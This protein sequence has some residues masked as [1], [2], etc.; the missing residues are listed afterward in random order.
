MQGVFC[1]NNAN[2]G[3]KIRKM[4]YFVLTGPLFCRKFLCFFRWFSAFSLKYEIIIFQYCSSGALL[5]VWRP[6]MYDRGGIFISHEPRAAEGRPAAAERNAVLMKNIRLPAFVLAL[7]LLSGCRREPPVS[8]PDPAPAEE[9]SIFVFAMD[10]IM[11]LTVYGDGGL[12]T[13]AQ[14]RILAL[15]ASLSVTDPD[16]EVYALNHSGSAVLSPE[17]AELLQFALDLCRRTEGALDLSIYP[18]LR[19]WGFT[20]GEYG[21]P[22]E[23][24]LARLLELVDY[25]RIGFDPDSRTVTLE[26]GM[27]IDF[28]SVAKGYTGDR[29]CA[30]LREG[31]VTSALLDLG[32][33]IQTVGGKPDGRPWRVGVKDPSGTGYVGV[34]E[35]EDKAVIT[36]GG[37]E[38]YFEQDGVVY[39]HLIDPGTGAPA[40]SG[41]ISAT[42]VGDSGRQ[43]DGLSTALFVMG[44]DR[45]AEFWREDG[46]FE[47]ILIDDQGGIHITE[48]LEDCFTLAEESALTLSVIRKE[49]K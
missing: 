41:L 42:I 38:R 23:A 39:W 25:T 27:E 1:R 21:V 40:R 37:Y 33:N 11:K 31:G 45:A 29:I 36:S 47:A 13:Q 48:G 44:L 7:L 5:T 46:A 12:L 43:C 16:S 49:G 19:A 2:P 26:P 34:L 10:T 3:L 14:D 22:E 32:G 24:E 18:V 30:L 6:M 17:A 20:T 15:E 4:R 28:G 9:H 8:V 35:V